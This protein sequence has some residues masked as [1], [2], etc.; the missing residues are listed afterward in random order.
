MFNLWFL[1]IIAIVRN[2]FLRAAGN[3]AFSLPN[4]RPTTVAVA[5]EFVDTFILRDVT[6]NSFQ[7][8]GIA[9]SSCLILRSNY[10]SLHAGYLRK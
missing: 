5:F 6:F 2:V 7:V 9:E 1:Q 3:I 8:S 10:F 4:V